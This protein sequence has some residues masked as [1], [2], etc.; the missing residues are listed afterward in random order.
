MSILILFICILLIAA[1]LLRRRLPI[2]FIRRYEKQ[3]AGAAAAAAIIGGLVLLVQVRGFE[4]K[5][6]VLVGALGLLTLIARQQSHWVL[7]ALRDQGID[8]NPFTQRLFSP[9]LGWPLFFM[10]LIIATPP[11]IWVDLIGVI[12]VY[13]IAIGYARWKRE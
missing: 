2:S 7:G 6:G 10:G 3:F 13:L 8:W 11:A 4:P 1:Y 12:I 5:L 9:L